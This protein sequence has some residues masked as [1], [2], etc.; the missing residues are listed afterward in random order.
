MRL[1]SSAPFLRRLAVLAV[2]TAAVWASAGRPA[3]AAAPESPRPS[4]RVFLTD[5]TPLVSAGEPV[6]TDGRVV[7]SLPIGD[8]LQVVTLP[9]STV[10]WDRTT[11]YADAVRHRRYAASQGEDDYLALSNQVARA[12][13]DMAFAPDAASKLRIGAGIRRQLAEWPAAHFGYRA[14]DIRDLIAIVDESLS[15][16]RAG[17]GE[18]AFD[19][20]LVATFG[21]PDEPLLPEPTLEEA[22]RLASSAA[23][24][25][26]S[27]HEKVS[28]QSAI[29]LVL[30]ERQAAAP[31]PWMRTATRR[32]RASLAFEA[33]LDRDYAAAASRAR[34]SAAPLAARG[35][36]KGV[37]TA[38]AELRRTDDRLGRQR[39]DTITRVVADLTAMLDVARE[40]RLALDRWRYRAETFG[41]YA[42]VVDSAMSTVSK[43]AKDIDAVRTLAGPSLKRLTGA[44]RDLAELDVSLLP[45]APP[46][47]LKGAHDTLLSAVKLLREAFRLRREATAAGDMGLAHNAS[48]AAAGGWLLAERV[49]ADV[50]AFFRK[51]EPR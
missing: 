22:V 21:A 40:N 8:A 3:A 28:L 44:D 47:E 27:S 50:A 19:I 25:S 36:V 5:G 42:R 31:E 35:D 38:L 41:A 20:S 24:A 16:V 43:H 37:E 11:R 51:P 14:E 23:R 2:V 32:A 18:Q 29:L 4:Y 1:A 12:L 7:F 13:S 9:D 6:R 17:S 45:V 30:V 48:A 39:P 33:R 46:Q 34:T 10:D 15:D 26:D 49:R